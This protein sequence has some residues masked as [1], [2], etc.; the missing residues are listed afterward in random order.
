MHHV[1]TDQLH[2]VLT[3]AASLISVASFVMPL[4]RTVCLFVKTAVKNAQSFLENVKHILH[5]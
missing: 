3:R 5:V 4:D 2:D 1:R